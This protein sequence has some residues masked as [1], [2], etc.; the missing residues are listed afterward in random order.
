MEGGTRAFRRN[1]ALKLGQV[2]PV[3]GPNDLLMSVLNV[4][5]GEVFGARSSL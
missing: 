3:P 1:Q 5:M 4:G 2:F